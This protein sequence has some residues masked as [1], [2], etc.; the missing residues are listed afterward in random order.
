MTDI[1]SSRTE[2]LAWPRGLALLL[3]FVLF[4]LVLRPAAHVYDMPQTEDGYYALSVARNLAEGHG[5]TIDGVHLTN[6][7]QPRLTMLEAGG[8]RG[9]KGDE[10]VAM[11]LVTALGWLF[12]IAGAVLI[13]L[14]ARDAWP[15]RYGD[16]ERQLRAGLAAFLYLAA[17]LMLNH[18]YNGLETGSVLFFYAAAARWM[19]TGRDRS[20]AGLA[21]FGVLIGLLVLARI[22]AGFVAAALGLNELRRAAKRG[23]IHALARGAVLG[24]VA[25][26][27][28]SP[29]WLYN[30]VYFG[31]PMPTSGTAQQAWA[32]EWLRLE[33]AEWALP[34]VLVPRTFPPP[35]VPP[36]P[37]HSPIP[38]S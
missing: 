22:D 7:F 23:L 20:G 16:T 2:S 31:S 19:Q 10:I 8:L 6:G 27:V 38:R 32:L 4:T 18:A 3:A 21:G 30:T 29:W 14:I 34:V 25:L 24:G 35:P 26:V 37:I 9:A 12:H 28:S 11:R 33:H 1:A 36:L 17:P 15:A 5:L 13:G